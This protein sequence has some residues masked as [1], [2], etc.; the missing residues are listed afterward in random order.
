M[1]LEDEFNLDLEEAEDDTSKASKGRREMSGRE[2]H[3]KTSNKANPAKKGMS[4]HKR[5]GLKRPGKNRRQMKRG[6]N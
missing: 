4:L 5:S 3:N 6:R 1:T 2:T